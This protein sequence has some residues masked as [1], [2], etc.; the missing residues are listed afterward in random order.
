[1]PQLWQLRKFDQPRRLSSTIDLR[2]TASARRVSGCSGMVRAA[3]V[4][5]AHG[6]K[7]APAADPLRQPH[8][9]QAVRG[10]RARRGR[11]GQQAGAGPA[12]ALGRDV[13]GVVARVALVLVGGVVLLVDHDQAE[14]R[15]RREDGRARADD[16]PRLAGAQPPPLVVALAVRERGVQQRDRVAEA[17]LEAGDGL[18]RQR[19][20]R[21]EHDHALAVGERLRGRAQV[22]LGL[23]RAGDAV[24]QPLPPLSTAATRLRL[25]GGELHRP[26]RRHVRARRAAA[27]PR[28]DRDQAA[29]LEPAQ[30]AEIGA[31][32]A[33]QAVE[34]G[35]LVVGDAPIRAG[36]LGP[37]R[38]LRPAGR[39]QHQRQRA[40]R[41]RAVL[42]GHPQRELHQV[43]RHGVAAHRGGRHQALGRQLARLGQP[44]HHA[45]ELLVAERNPHHRAHPRPLRR[46]VVERAGQPAGGG[47][48]LDAGDHAGHADDRPRRRR[49]GPMRRYAPWRGSSWAT[50]CRCCESSED[51]CAQLVYAD[52]PFNT[53]RTQ[54]RRSLATVGRG[55]RRP[56]RVRRAPLR[57][58]AAG[59]VLLPRRVRRLPRASSRP[60]WRRSAASCTRRGTLYLHLDYREA[61]YVKLLLDELFGRECFLN[62]LIWAYDYGAKSRAAGRQKHDTILVY[63]K[64][65]AAYYFDAEAVDREPYMAPG[66]VT[67][68]KAERGKRAVSVIVAHDRLPHRPRED[69][70]PDAEAR[71]ARPPL[72]AGLL[73]AGRPV[74]GPV[75]RVGD[76][77]GRGGASSAAATC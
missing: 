32:R 41:R 27:G 47:E 35:A 7:A 14:P 11:A 68:E 38:R 77:R 54:T 17:R 39:R 2:A 9:A 73:A 15:H 53:G 21:D 71:G 6:R 44:D 58:Q 13:A 25:G 8:P 60:G 5:H 72:R 43:V 12:G 62:E 59:R 40:G 42:L 29:P 63:V 37:Q 49:L 55:R 10:L 18:R 30:G 28:G 23:A 61:H 22:D 3:H 31:G 70:L 52:P 75:R 65:P 74:P 76:A 56:D 67:P 48:R 26:I 66:L 1:M 24:Q 16:D 46:R 19:D 64:D 36:R 51:S 4:E 20:L 34:Q 33:G 69:R 50:T 45:V 57:H